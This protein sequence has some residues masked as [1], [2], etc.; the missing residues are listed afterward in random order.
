MNSWGKARTTPDLRLSQL[1]SRQHGVVH[2]GQ[3]R[4]LGMSDKEIEYR[5]RIGR[6]HRLHRGVYAVGHR[7]LTEESTFI[8]AVLA[9]GDD[10]V[11]GGMAALALHG[12]RRWRGGDVDVIVTR[13]VA[14]R[15]GIVPHCIRLDP[16][17]VTSRRGIPVT[18]PARTLLDV[19]RTAPP[20]VARRAVNQ[21]LVDRK[22]TV[23]LLYRQAGG[24]QGARLRGL[25]AN[26]SPTRSELEDVAVEFLRRHD[27]RFESNFGLAGYEV[28]FWLPEHGLVLETDGG[29]FHDNPIQRAD[30]ERKQGALEAAGHRVKRLRWHDL[31]CASPT[32]LVA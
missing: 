14:R 13:R 23:P 18:T 29:Q 20:K 27:I 9:I 1:A 19:G 5:S 8:G 22:V 6:L 12:F 15:R 16:R 30:D 21:A 7:N 25:L 26:A 11:L 2:I 10:A 24:P 17:D 4:L 3:L 28:D 32:S 31:L